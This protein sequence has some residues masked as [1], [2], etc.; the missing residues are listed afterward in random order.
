LPDFF[1]TFIADDD[2]CEPAKFHYELSDILLREKK[3]FAIEMFRESAKS[4]YVLRAFPLYKLAYPTDD[5]HYIVIIKQNQDLASAKLVEIIDFYKNN[6]VLNLNLVEI[7]KDSA[8][9]AEIIVRGTDGK[10]HTV[11]IEAYGKGASIRGLTWGNFRPQVIIMDD[12]QDYEDSRSETTLEKDW[13][14]FLGDVLFLAKTGRIFII[15]NNLGKKCVLERIVDASEVMQFQKMK[16]SAIDENGNSAWPTRF[17]NEFLQTEKEKYISL[18]QLDVWYRERMCEAITPETQMF[19]PEYLKEFDEEKLPKDLDVDITVDPAISKKKDACNSAIVAVGKST[20][21]PN[22]YILDCYADKYDPF[23]LI[24]AI[25]KMFGELRLKYPSSAIRVFVETVAYQQ[26]LKYYIEEEMR[27]R[28]EFFILEEFRDTTDKE[29]R[30]KGLIPLYR[31]GVIYHRSWMKQLIEELLLF[32]A[33]KTVDIIDALSFHLSIKQNTTKL[34]LAEVAGRM[35]N[36][37]I[38]LA[39]FI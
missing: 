29:Q 31:T 19:R 25:F 30:I 7:K 33:G 34:D 4:S 17:T 2:W 11:R 3:H 1:Y 5:C 38:N 15:G 26:S 24:N 8:K 32:P 6:K 28:K 35:E 20:Y 10:N 18:G 27:K 39:Q 16:I 37:K 12:I 13:E 36:E 23:E 9:S 14:W 21:S 22:W